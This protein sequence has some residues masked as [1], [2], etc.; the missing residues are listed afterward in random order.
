MR[1]TSTVFSSESGFST[2]SKAPILMAR[3]ADSMLPCPE[4]TTTCASTSPLAQPRQRR[5]PVDAGQ[6]DVEHD[7]VEAGVQRAVEAGLAGLDG[8]DLVALVA[9]HAAKRRPRTPGS[10][11]TIRTVGFM[12]LDA[13][14]STHS[15]LPH[16]RSHSYAVTH[17]NSIVNRVPRGTLSPTSMLPPCSAMIR[18]TMARPSPLPRRLVE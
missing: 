10:S 15:S 1:T 9:Q 2:K 8:F 7:H 11:S 4:I 16:S 12:K 3:T 6:P 13:H 18:R 14:S 17:G 5:E